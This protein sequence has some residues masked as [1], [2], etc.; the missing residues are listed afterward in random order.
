VCLFVSGCRPINEVCVANG[1]CCSGQCE[2]DVESGGVFRCARTR[3]P[4]CLRPGEVCWEGMSRNC[5]TT[6]GGQGGGT[7][8]CIDT[9]IGINRCSS[10]EALDS[11]L[12]DGESCA[13][14]DDCCS[15]LCLRDE[16][17][18]YSCSSQCV[19]LG[20]PCTASGDCCDGLPCERGLCAPN[21]QECLPFAADCEDSED[22][23]SGFC[24][25]AVGICLS[26]LE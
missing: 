24:D 20:A 26:P 5:C 10:D 19:S 25:H 6:S 23:C 7:E 2:E 8:A 15:G 17:G 21:S 16:D 4:G 1:D 9:E 12:D 13:M 14:A 3:E 11:C 18:S 22:C